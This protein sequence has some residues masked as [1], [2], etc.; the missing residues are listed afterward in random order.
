[1][2][3]LGWSRSLLVPALLGGS[4]AVGVGTA[5][6]TPAPRPVVTTSAIARALR[7]AYRR[8]WPPPTPYAPGSPGHLIRVTAPAST[9]LG[10]EERIMAEQP[11]WTQAIWLDDGRPPLYWSS[12]VPVPAPGEAT[13]PG[14]RGTY[15]FCRH[16]ATGPR[17]VSAV[18]LPGTAGENAALSR[19]PW[20]GRPLRPAP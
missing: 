9:V 10:Q 14:A 20:Y 7:L 6:A 19:Y 17:C 16:P 18:I 2:L 3:G 4:V 12:W 11:A 15:Y 1:M 13:V 5:L 8:L